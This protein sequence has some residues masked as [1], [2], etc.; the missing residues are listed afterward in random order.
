MFVTLLISL[1][2]QS[3]SVLLKFDPVVGEITRYRMRIEDND[4]PV[5]TRNSPA[6]CIFKVVGKK[7]G[8]FSL[9]HSFEKIETDGTKSTKPGDPFLA[10]PLLACTPIGHAKGFDPTPE[11]I[12]KR[13]AG[14]FGVCFSSKAVKV[15]DQWELSVDA[16]K[17]ANEV[18][19]YLIPLPK[20]KFKSKVFERF[21][22]SG[23]TVDSADIRSKIGCSFDAVE[24]EK[25]VIQHLTLTISSVQVGTF[26]LKTGMPS[27]IVR[28]TEMTIDFPG[29]NSRFRS[30]VR[31]T[32]EN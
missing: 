23:L 24:I 29:N 15:G 28:Q 25:G 8:M 10:S 22:L 18:F 12:L 20:I 7:D 16:D 14:P 21:D 3:E 5:T 31:L 26:N 2:I 1:A 32:R 11:A 17:V 30:I 6:Y 9:N 27:S 19:G 13:A 4:G